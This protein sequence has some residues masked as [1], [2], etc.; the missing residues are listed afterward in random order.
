MAPSRWSFPV[1]NIVTSGLSVGTVVVEAGP[2]SGARQQAQ[3]ALRHGK[4]LFLL[5]RLVEHQPW[6]QELMKTPGV[7]AIDDIEEILAAI[8][9]ELDL[10]A[11]VVWSRAPA[12]PPPQRCSSRCG[13]ASCR[14]RPPA[15]PACAAT[16]TAPATRTT[17]S[18]IPCLE[19]V[20]SVGAVDILPISMSVDGE[21]L[22]RHLRGYKDDRSAD[23]RDRMSLR[24]AALA[25]GVPR[26]SS[27]L[28]RPVRL[29]GARPVAGEDGSRG[30]RPAGPVV[31]G[32]VPA[33]AEGDGPRLQERTAY[34]PLR[35]DAW[36]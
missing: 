29:G 20:R 26:A 18:A 17:G 11:D 5:Q 1:R 27:R 3:H 8:E 36:M 24:L 15:R 21:L 33:G 25:C 35:S 30:D 2:T 10:Q 7:V 4:R 32:R 28:R 22:H 14:C 12:W 31:S 34:R 16:A 19:A 6:A 23:V 9:A 13:R